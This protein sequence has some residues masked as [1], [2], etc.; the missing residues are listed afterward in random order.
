MPKAGV[1]QARSS[2]TRY[3]PTKPSPT[4]SSPTKPF[5]RK[6]LAGDFSVPLGTTRTSLPTF[7]RS[8]V[9]TQ[10][11][12][13][14]RAPNGRKI[15]IYDNLS[16]SIKS[17]SAPQ[18]WLADDIFSNT[19]SSRA[20]SPEPTPDDQPSIHKD[21]EEPTF[22]GMMDIEAA[23]DEDVISKGLVMNCHI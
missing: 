16:S 11:S 22:P 18:L 17:P 7:P 10:D 8:T 21:K 3:S 23:L 6:N 13:Y 9:K 15:R 2:A 14:G 1:S 19:T 20:I 5:Y 12:K 4:K